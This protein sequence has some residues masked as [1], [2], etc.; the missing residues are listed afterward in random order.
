[1]KQS[2]STDAGT[3]LV[4]REKELARVTNAMTKS[5]VERVLAEASPKLRD[6]Q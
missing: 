4:S 3:R 2:S 1:M 6:L 5:R